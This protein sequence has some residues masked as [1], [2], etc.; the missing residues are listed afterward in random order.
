VT[1]GFSIVAASDP[2]E[3]AGCAFEQAARLAHRIP[4]AAVD[5]V[6]VMKDGAVEARIRPLAANTCCS[7]VTASEAGVRMHHPLRA[8]RHTRFHGAKP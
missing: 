1:Q 8:R 2:S 4:S 6:H 7:N 5:L 3:V